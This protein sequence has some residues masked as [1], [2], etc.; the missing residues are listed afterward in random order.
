MKKNIIKLKCIAIILFIVSPFN[1]FL[2][3][4]KNDTYDITNGKRSSLENDVAGS[5]INKIE[6]KLLEIINSNNKD[7]LNTPIIILYNY[8]DENFKEKIEEESN[9]YVYNYKIIPATLVYSSNLDI[10]SIAKSPAVK[11]IVLDKKVYPISIEK[12]KLKEEYHEDFTSENHY[13]PLVNQTVSQIGAPYLWDSGFNGSGVLVAVLDT[14]IDKTH[15]DLNDLDDN[16]LTIDD[17]K[18]IY[19]KSFI[20]FDYNGIPEENTDDRA[21]HGTHVAGIISGTGEGSS[22]KFKGVAPGSRLMNV[23]VLTT[24][25]GFESWIIKG[26]EYAILGDDGDPNT[27]DDADI[28]SMSLGGSGFMDDPLVQAVE[29]AWDLNKTVVI[30]AGNSGRN[31]FTIESPGLSTKAIT[32]GAVDQND[33]I[34]YFSSR[35]PTPDLKMGIDICAPGVDIISA[36]ANLTSSSGYGNYT[37]KSGT[38]MATPFVAGA[39]ALLLQSNPNLLPSTIKTLL[40]VSAVDIGESSYTQGAGRLDIYA[41]YCFSKKLTGIST[42][43]RQ[44]LTER[45]YFDNDGIEGRFQT[46]FYSGSLGDY[47][48][49]GTNWKIYEDIWDTF[50]A[51][52]YNTI[53]GE[54]FYLS[55]DLIKNYPY[56]M[57]LLIDNSTHRVATESLKTPDGILKIDIFYELYN[58]SKWMR[59]S[60]NITSLGGIE[61]SNTKFYYYMDADIYEQYQLNNEE[62]YDDDAV[63]IQNLN[64]LVANDTYYDNITDPIFG[65]QPNNYLGFS[66]INKSIAFEVNSYY[67]AYLNMLNDDITNNTFYHGDVGLVQEWLNVTIS[68]NKHAFLPIIIAFGD[69]KSHFIDNI[70]KGK[71]TPYFNLKSDIAINTLSVSNPIY[72][73]TKAFLN[74]SVINVGFTQSS[75]FDVTT[76]L[77]GVLINETKINGLSP[78]GEAMIRIPIKFNNTGIYKITVVADFTPSE[79][80]E[81][82]WN[83]R[84]ERNIKVITPFFAAFFPINP[85]DNPM[86]LKYAGQFLYWNCYVS[87]GENFSDLKLNKTGDGISFVSFNGTLTSSNT[88]PIDGRLGQSFINIS[89]DVPKGLTGSYFFDLQLLNSNVIISE[90][91]IEFNLIEDLPVKLLIT[92]MTMDDAGPEDEDGIIEGEEYGEVE[93]FVNSTEATDFISDIFMIVSSKND[94]TIGIL[95]YNIFID[96]ELYYNDSSWSKDYFYFTVPYNFSN[97]V[98]EFNS[99]LY[100]HIGYSNDFIPFFHNKFNCSIQQR[101]PGIPDLEFDSYE[102]IDF[103]S[104]DN[105]GLVEPGEVGAIGLF[106]KNIGD[107]SALQIF[108]TNFS[109]SDSRVTIPQPYYVW[110]IFIFRI[111]I[112][113]LYIQWNGIDPGD[114]TKTFSSFPVFILSSSIPPSTVLYF[115]IEIEYFNTTGDLFKKTFQFSYT[116][117]SISGGGNGGGN[118]DDDGEDDDL[119]MFILGTTVGISSV[120]VVVVSFFYIRKKRSKKIKERLSK[121]LQ[122]N[123][124]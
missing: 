28:I 101:V 16:P 122:K 117:P 64:A 110:Q 1:S 40:M 112:P 24:Y 41:A 52:R 53:E 23:K 62:N 118:G 83:N 7:D 99:I 6:P 59:I 80:I 21:G 77:D 102:V 116:V 18:V 42:L 73:G 124:L 66:S 91:R 17:D 58:D 109:C 76:Y 98:V 97:S 65:Y 113:T 120:A 2:F 108:N 32:V 115:E 44:D 31:F 106:F 86:K 12:R 63:Y 92:N 27:D 95:D 57:R 4:S 56:E 20:D 96:Y 104:S 81:S 22:Y 111:F 51:I 29:A 88:L 82:D 5:E 103:D 19:E 123:G 85:L 14:G 94:T 107:G 74:V 72:N 68:Q 67:E 55:T 3:S 69:N 54:Q 121:L 49:N 87:K 39:I 78:K 48:H 105:D 33:E 30:A 43:R 50:F 13:I 45:I 84:L 26:I 90:V 89:I 35:G 15:P 79:F 10:Y 46:P 36:R 61:A 11:K 25:G 119:Y 9:G 100:A 93:F 8:H 38:S 114:S 37:S 71:N 34:A 70:K 47:H 60:F 75:N